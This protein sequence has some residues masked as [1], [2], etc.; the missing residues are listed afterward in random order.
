MSILGRAFTAQAL[1]S[2]GGRRLEPACAILASVLERAG[3][4]AGTSVT[5]RLD[6]LRASVVEPLLDSIASACATA[7]DATKCAYT[8]LDD[9]VGAAVALLGI[10]APVPP[11]LDLTRGDTCAPFAVPF[12]FDIVVRLEGGALVEAAVVSLLGLL[13]AAVPLLP[14]PRPRRSAD[15]EPDDFPRFDQHGKTDPWQALDRLAGTLSL[16]EDDNPSSALVQ[17]AL[18]WAWVW[19][20]VLARSERE[21]AAVDDLARLLAPLLFARL[22]T[23]G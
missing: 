10:G 2:E 8:P 6:A 19:E 1:D 5:V 23:K 9:L 13:R 14:P 11:A 4:S 20:G 15:A 12:V 3:D 22:A 7:E 16:A 17:D 21:E 18:A